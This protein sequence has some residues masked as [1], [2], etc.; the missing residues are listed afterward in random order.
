MHGTVALNSEFGMRVG[1]HQ[2]FSEKLQYWGIVNDLPSLQHFSKGAVLPRHKKVASCVPSTCIA[3]QRVPEFS[4]NNF[5]ESSKKTFMC[6]KFL[7]N[8]VLQS[9]KCYISTN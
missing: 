3:N 2:T 8:P 5:A 7:T 9:T 1:V 6:L 4:W